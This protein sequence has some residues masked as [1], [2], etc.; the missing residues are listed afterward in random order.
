VKLRVIIILV[1]SIPVVAWYFYKPVRVLFPEF[2]GVVCVQEH[3][4]LESVDM[5]EIAEKLYVNSQ[6]YVQATVSNFEHRPKFIFCETQ[7]CF[8]GFGF[9]KASAQSIGKVAIVVGPNGWKQHIV[10]HEMIH[11][12]QNE[13]LGTIKFLSMPAWFVEG[14]AYSLSQD[15]R[16]VLSEPWESYRNTFNE[17]YQIVGPDNLWQE[18]KKL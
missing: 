13:K 14:M 16:E 7:S 8:E 12:I 4:C 3:M 11:Y 2:A 6:D 15:P 17:W 18:A 9:S 5:I 1:L 10:Q